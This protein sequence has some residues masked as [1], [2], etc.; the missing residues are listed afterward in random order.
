MKNI[1]DESYFP[2][3]DIGLLEF[4]FD[5]IS[6]ESVFKKEDIKNIPISAIKDYIIGL[7]IS[8]SVVKTAI[9]ILDDPSMT[10]D[11]TVIGLIDAALARILTRIDDAYYGDIGKIILD[12]AI[13]INKIA[14][15]YYNKLKDANASEK[16]LRIYKNVL[17][18]T[19]NVIS[20]F[21]K[22]SKK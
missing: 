20:T 13:E 10:P 3:I 9:I 21:K 15:K 22:N 14:K 12:S 2:D 17:D 8:N 1:N 5:T 4:E 6:N 16:V 18:Y 7:L 19:Q 11:N